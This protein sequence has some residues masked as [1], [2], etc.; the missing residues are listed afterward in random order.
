MTL[1]IHLSKVH[2]PLLYDN[3]SEND[4]ATTRRIDIDLGLEKH[5]SDPKSMSAVN[6][7]RR[8]YFG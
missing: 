2:P 3:L 6:T 1:V 4:T 8:H 5:S 7:Q